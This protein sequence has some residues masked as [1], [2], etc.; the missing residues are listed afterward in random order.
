[1]LN[2]VIKITAVRLTAVPYFPRWKGPAGKCR[3]LVRTFAK[4]GIAYEIVVRM[5]KEPVR[6]RNAV[7]EPRGMAPSPV[8]MTADTI[9]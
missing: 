1:M 5:M 7:D 6:S 4:K 2:M 9:R 3:R 8:A